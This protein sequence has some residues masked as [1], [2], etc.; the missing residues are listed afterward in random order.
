MLAGGCCP[1][2]LALAASNRPLTRGLGR[3]LSPLYKGPWPQSVTPLQ[4]A[5]PWL[6]ALA[7]GLAIVGCPLSSLRLLQKRSKNGTYNDYSFVA[8]CFPIAPV[9]PSSGS[10]GGAREGAYQ[11]EFYA[12]MEKAVLRH[13][14]FQAHQLAI[15]VRAGRGA[16]CRPSDITISQTRTGSIVEGKP[17]YEVMVSNNCKCLQSQVLLQCYGL[18]SVEPV[19]RHAIR[20]VDE[21]RCIVGDGR[22]IS[23]RT[24]VKFKYAWMTPQDFPVIS[25]QIQN[26]H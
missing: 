16:S 12:A 11:D 13:P 19:N 22:P 3:S 14:P 20:P 15:A 23:R 25:T 17:E 9:S 8:T 10:D 1:Y 18:S 7:D 6:T 21:E 24:P 26:C 5:R 2:G 4:V